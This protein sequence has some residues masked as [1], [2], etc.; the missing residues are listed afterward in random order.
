MGDRIHIQMMG[1]FIIYVNGQRTS[2]LPNKSYKGLALMQYLIMNRETAVM[3]RRLFAVF[4]ADER[5]S[6]PENALKTL[7]SRMRTQLN[8]IFPGLGKCIVAERGAYRWQSLPG[9]TVDVY[10]LEDCFASL[11]K[12]HGEKDTAASILY[13]RILRLYTGDLLR[14]CEMSEWAFSQATL[15]HNQYLTA[16]HSYIDLLKRKGEAKAVIAVCRRVRQVDPFDDQTRIEMMTALLKENKADEARAQYDEI[17]N[18]HYHYLNTEPSKK[19]KDFYQQIAANTTADFSLE[20][21]CRELTDTSD[22]G[23]ALYCEY[24][25]F[26]E[27][28]NVSI[29][30]IERLGF[31][32]M[33]AIMMIIPSNDDP[34]NA[35][36]QKTVM[37][38]L[39]DILR[40]NLNKGDIITEY[41]PQMAVLLLPMEKPATGRVTL[42]R[43]TKKF[44]QQYAKS[45]VVLQYKVSPINVGGGGKW[46][47]LVAGIVGRYNIIGRNPFH[48]PNGETA[49]VA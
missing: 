45:K 47:R 8:Q 23:K 19:L 48:H 35:P 46:I 6:N 12:L 38:G 28:F 30:N 37:R 1:D 25:V 42:E 18:L 26:K 24:S 33:L 44:Y 49:A 36:K 22:D 20:A 16:V 27:I 2:A 31:H 14:N 15:L 39:I 34:I 13:E 17:I 10:E 40:A 29:R 32:M 4:W 9:M 43:V 21:I 5:V 3:N 41:S 11:F 7:V